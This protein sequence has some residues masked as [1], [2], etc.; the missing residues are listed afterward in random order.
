MPDPEVASS[1]EVAIEQAEIAGS[2]ESI[3][4]NCEFGVFQRFCGIE[5]LGLFR[6]SATTMASL[7][8]LLTT[9][10]SG[11]LGPDDLTI[12][13]QPQDR[14]YITMSKGYADF[15]A[16]TLIDEHDMS[17]EVVT[18]QQLRKFGYLVEKFRR[19]L[20][21]GAKIYLRVGEERIEDIEMLQARLA[22]HGD[23][24]LLWVNASG[25]PARRGVVERIGPRILHGTIAHYA[26]F[27]G[28]PRLDLQGWM[29][30]CRRAIALARGIDED[31]PTSD[32]GALSLSPEWT[33]GS[34]CT[35]A[36]LSDAEGGQPIQR[37]DFLGDTD[38]GF[39]ALSRQSSAAPAE[40]SLVVLSAWLWLP[41]NF[42]GQRVDLRFRDLTALHDRYGD[43]RKRDMWQQIWVAARI[44][45]GMESLEVCL[46]ADSRLGD[47]LY[48]TSW[49]LENGSIPGEMLRPRKDLGLSSL[50]C[51]A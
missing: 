36:L 2:F 10:L 29:M 18:A 9:N 30:V 24:T 1:Q 46:H 44:A 27:E 35:Q 6:Y 48:L 47:R 25:D 40:R 43:L 38:A 23:N 41:S 37:L 15:N 45:K 22:A 4:A 39:I 28:G 11:F 21:E 51:E 8:R 16:H 20:E 12:T 34:S 31:P 14:E 50:G 33:V 32:I 26:T 49:H 7:D 13:I 42:A 19:D 17:L 3:G 5:P